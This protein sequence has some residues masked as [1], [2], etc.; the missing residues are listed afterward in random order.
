M[1]ADLHA[2]VRGASV[3]D[4]RRRTDGT[5][6]T[7]QEML[8]HMV[9]GYMI[10]RRLLPLGRLFGRLPDRFSRTF[11]TLLNTATR[12]FTSS[13]TSARRGERSFFMDRVSPGSS[14][15][16]STGSTGA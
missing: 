14:T 3:A 1:R 10:V 12:P 9:S 4:L 11:A 6:W 8:F 7:N 16:R 13:T 2:L 5:R 15:A